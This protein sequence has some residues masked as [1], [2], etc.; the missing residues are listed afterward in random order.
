MSS[1]TPRLQGPKSGAQSLTNTLCPR[2][3][4][5]ASGPSSRTLNAE[6]QPVT[7]VHTHRVA[8]SSSSSS[9]S[10]FPITKGSALQEKDE[11]KVM[12]LGLLSQWRRS[13]P[14][15]SNYMQR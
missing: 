10:S 4:A 6:Q 13:A 15:A 11:T 2:T 3:E 8:A 12:L 14:G 7:S 9:S 1:R 5:A